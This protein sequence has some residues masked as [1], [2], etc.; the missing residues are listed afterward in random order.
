[1][2]LEDQDL[3]ELGFA[4]P[5]KLYFVAWNFSSTWRIMGLSK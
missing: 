4:K 2:Y 3:L 5:F 1:M